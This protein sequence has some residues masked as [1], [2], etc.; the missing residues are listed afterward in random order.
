MAPAGDVVPCAHGLQDAAPSTE[1]LVPGAHSVHAEAPAAEYVPTGHTLHDVSP[2]AAYVPATHGVHNN[3]FPAPEV[4][5]AGQ[6]VHDDVLVL[7]L[8]AFVHLGKVITRA[9][10]TEGALYML[11]PLYMVITCRPYDSPTGTTEYEPGN[12]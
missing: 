8:C 12:V 7:Y 9:S 11:E 2:A 6:S 5:P 3:L 4:V 1:E 10:P